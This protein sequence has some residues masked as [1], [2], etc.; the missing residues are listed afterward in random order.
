[1][2]SLP[3][4]NIGKNTGD[5]ATVERVKKEINY[6]EKEWGEGDETARW[7]KEVDL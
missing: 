6:V 7:G 3:S 4:D 2:F 5:K 1:M